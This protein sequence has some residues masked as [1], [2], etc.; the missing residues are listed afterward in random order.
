MRKTIIAIAL[1]SVSMVSQGEI[2]PDKTTVFITGA[3]R[4]I[5]FEFVE[6]Y[7]KRGWNVIATTRKPETSD[8][9]KALAA[10]RKNI[11]IEQLDVT[12]HARIDALAEKYKKHSIDQLISNAALTPK[13]VS[14]F[15]SVDNVDFDIARKSLEVNAIGPL[16]LAQAFMPHVE[17]SEQKKILI[18]SSKAGSFAHSPKRAMM[19]SYRASKSA[20]NMYMYTL[21]FETKDKGIILTMMSPG[22]V[23]TMGFLGKLL[24][25]NITTQESV[26]KMIAVFDALKP[27]HNGVMVSHEDGSTIEW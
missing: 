2:I 4:G 24:P 10:E 18:I 14:A 15:R 5:G 19:Y 26:S 11:T 8:D 12:D 7:S 23:N 13:Y 27:E 17:A 20:L 1:L 16:K 9:L 6:Q 25:G 21:S 22:R 3:N